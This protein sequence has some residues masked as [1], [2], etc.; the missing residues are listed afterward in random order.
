MMA[1]VLYLDC[2]SGA[3]GDMLIGALLDAGLPFDL[4]F[5]SGAHETYGKPPI[6]RVV[7]SAV[8]AMKCQ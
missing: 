5:P 2:F 3:S 6:T 8:N 7:T 1:R 4:S